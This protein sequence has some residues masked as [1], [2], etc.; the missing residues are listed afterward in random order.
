MTIRFKVHPQGPDTVLA[1]ADQSALGIKHADPPATPD[2]SGRTTP[3]RVLDLA[4]FRAFYDGETADEER[5]ASLLS[6]CTSANLVGERAVAVA[7]KAG[8]ARAEHV[9]KIGAVPHLQLYRIPKDG[10]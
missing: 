10:E 8:L 3:R 1:A 2:A 6:T 9:V 4:L 7:L 5:L